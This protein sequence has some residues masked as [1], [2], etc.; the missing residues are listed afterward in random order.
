MTIIKRFCSN[1]TSDE[2][3]IIRF[4][5]VNIIEELVSES[6]TCNAFSRDDDKFALLIACPEEK[7]LVTLEDEI[8]L[9]FQSIQKNIEMHLHFTLTV[10]FSTFFRNLEQLPA[11]YKHTEV[12]A[13][14]NAL[15]SQQ[16]H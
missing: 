11:I 2:L 14:K 5:V 1:T 3:W 6:F 15:W 8:L 4:S 7:D 12:V 13:F 10:A 9:L 16:Y